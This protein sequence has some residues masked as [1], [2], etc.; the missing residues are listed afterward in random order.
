MRNEVPP[1]LPY[2]LELQPS[3]HPILDNLIEGCQI[4]GFDWYYLYVNRVITQP[5][6]PQLGDRATR[7]YD[8][9]SMMS[10]LGGSQLS[11]AAHSLRDKN[12]GPTSS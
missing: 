2:P 12:A 9:I 6:R 3:D 8:D 5:R 4:I 10:K 7:E 11:P 1:H